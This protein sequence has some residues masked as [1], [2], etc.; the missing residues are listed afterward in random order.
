MPTLYRCVKPAAVGSLKRRSADRSEVAF[1]RALF[2]NV[3][4]VS[5][6]F[7]TLSKLRTFMGRFATL[8]A[9]GLPP[10]AL[11]GSAKIKLSPAGDL[12]VGSTARTGVG[13][14]LMPFTLLKT[15]SEVG[16]C[17]SCTVLCLFSTQNI[18]ELFQQSSLHSGKPLS[19]LGALK[20]LYQSGGIKSLW[21][22]AVP[23]ALRDA[24]NAGLFIV[25]YERGRRILGVR[26]D[27]GGG[28]VGGGAA[29]ERGCP[30]CQN[31]RHELT[32]GV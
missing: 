22:G 24:P 27:A 11:D 23:T 31:K 19:T 16:H 25:F 30:S 18:D 29:G 4:G 32:S 9:K 6:Y 14:I 12:L 8:R 26:G 5:M 20:Q 2:R 17:G 7:L 1:L 3:P 15:L 10:Q 28:A 13:F 21:R